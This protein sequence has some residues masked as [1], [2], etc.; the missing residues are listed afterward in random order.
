M[1]FLPAEREP[2]HPCKLPWIRPLF[3]RWL[4]VGERWQCDACDEIWVVSGP[5]CPRHPPVRWVKWRPMPTV[6]PGPAQG[7][8]SR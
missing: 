2:S 1:G 7:A 5:N 4:D 8:K 3:R 6:P